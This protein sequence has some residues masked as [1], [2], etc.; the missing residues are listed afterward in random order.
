[1]GQRR[2]LTRVHEHIAAVGG[3]MQQQEAA[4]AQART[5][6]L[7]QAQGGADR[8]RRAEGIATLAQ[9]FHPATGGVGIAAGDGR[10]LQ[11]GP[12]RRGRTSR[13][14]QAQGG[15]DRDRR[16]EGIAT[17]GQHFHAGI[18]GVGIGA[19]D[20]RAL[21]RRPPRRY[22]GPGG[23]NQQQQGQQQQSLHAAF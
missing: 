4:T 8:D 13:A 5:L 1:G 23:G 18:G 17:L 22:I 2:P 12:P 21:R 14:G 10:A 19:G 15:A 20:G 3:H 9:H 6:R 16:V 7:D 11:G